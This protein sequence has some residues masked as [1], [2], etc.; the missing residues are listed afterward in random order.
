MRLLLARIWTG[1][2]KKLEEKREEALTGAS[3]FWFPELVP[4]RN[5]RNLCRLALFARLRGNHRFGMVHV[6]HVTTEFPIALLSI[7]WVISLAI[8]GI[9]GL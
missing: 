8:Y 2:V 7:S 4:L 3:F 6:V 5:V 9:V 1:R